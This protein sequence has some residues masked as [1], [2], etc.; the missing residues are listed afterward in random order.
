MLLHTS[1]SR[2]LPTSMILPSSELPRFRPVPSQRGVWIAECA[3][4]LSEL[5]PADE[6]AALLSVAA[7]LWSEVSSFDPVLAAEMEHESWSEDI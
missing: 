6:R 5:R 1:V 2:P 7:D 4:R 3:A